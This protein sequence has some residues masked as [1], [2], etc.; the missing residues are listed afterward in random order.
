MKWKLHLA[1]ALLAFAGP[2][3]AQEDRPQPP[4]EPEVAEAAADIL[5]ALKL[6]QVAER[7]REAGVPREDVED[8]VMAAKDRGM[9]PGET[10]EILEASSEAVDDHGPV[11][12]FGAFVQARLDEGLRGRDLAAAI[13]AEHEAR[14]IGKGKRLERADRPERGRPDRGAHP[15]ARGGTDRDGNA[16]GPSARPARPGGARPGGPPARRPGGGGGS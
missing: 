16:R 6:P 11:D 14:G 7:V 4:V 2:L 1:L 12:N 9:S 3:A 10:A 13:R 15:D 5:A 8:V